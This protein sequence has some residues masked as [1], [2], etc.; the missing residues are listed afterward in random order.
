MSANK[1]DIKYHAKYNNIK[2]QYERLKHMIKKRLRSLIIVIV[3]ISIVAG[4]VLYP[5][6]A[7]DTKYA[8]RVINR[9]AV[10]I[11]LTDGTSDSTGTAKLKPGQEGTYITDGIV[12][13]SSDDERYKVT[14]WVGYGGNSIDCN[15]IDLASTEDRNRL[16][17]PE[18]Y[19]TTEVSNI[20]NDRK[21]PE[22]LVNGVC[23]Y[24]V[25]A[26]VVSLVW[27]EKQGIQMEG[28]E[29]D[30]IAD[31]EFDL[32]DYLKYVDEDYELLAWRAYGDDENVSMDGHITVT[33][34]LTRLYV[35][36]ILGAKITYLNMDG[37]VLEQSE[38]VELESEIELIGSD[39][40]K[41]LDFLGWSTSQN[42]DPQ[43]KP[44]E[45]V[46]VERNM[47]LYPVYKVKYDRIAS[48][49]KY[50]L[51]SGCRYV[52]AAG[53]RLAGDESIYASEVSFYVPQNGYYTF[54]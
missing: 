33:D 52:L 53:M 51:R 1:I 8:A 10:D 24:P 2:I 35:D 21:A 25:L 29:H 31:K 6:A 32:A 47:I 7:G 12:E 46:C 40:V 4:Y 48:P 17:L 36:P 18:D 11:V 38:T 28:D 34:S 14:S 26:R 49:G 13:A 3:C 42:T 9:S 16:S 23:L 50:Y 27:D 39:E 22:Y 37:E 19:L 45:T 5:E 43:Y 30:V 20:L 15:S 41:G 54:E 44:G